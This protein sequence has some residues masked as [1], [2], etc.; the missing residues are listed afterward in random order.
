[1]SHD[2]K[3]AKA[4]ASFSS[5]WA[6]AVLIRLPLEGTPRIEGTFRLVLTQAHA[7]HADTW[8]QAADRRGVTLEEFAAQAMDEAA[9][10][11]LA[12]AA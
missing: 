7:A 8:R 5:A 1:M 9:Q 12:K 6:P 2:P 3:L 10:V 11:E 4:L